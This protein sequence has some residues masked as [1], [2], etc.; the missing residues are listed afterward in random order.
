MHLLKIENQRKKQQGMTLIELI[1]VLMASSVLIVAT[2]PFMR[3]NINSYIQIRNAKDGMSMARI[4]MNAMVAALRSMSNFERGESDGI[5]FD[6]KIGGVYENNWQYWYSD[7]DETL[8]K[9]QGSSLPPLTY[10]NTSPLIV[11]VTDFRLRYFDAS[12]T[13]MST[14]VTSSAT[15]NVRRI[16][17]LVSV[18][19]PEGNTLTLK[20]QVS[21]LGIQ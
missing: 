18:S 14:P 9:D 19:D 21:P 12:G 13:Q 17:V 10:S 16:E 6:T 20:T 5:V 1:V 2:L 8:F 11:G 3:T 15:L 4:G 7:D